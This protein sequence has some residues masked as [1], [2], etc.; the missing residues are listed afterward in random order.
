MNLREAPRGS[1]CCSVLLSSRPPRIVT[2]SFIG[3]GEIDPERIFPMFSC[4]LSLSVAGLRVCLVFDS[5]L[6]PERLLKLSFAMCSI[7]V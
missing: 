7:I 4:C 2:Y 5:F 1:V 6:L 3:L